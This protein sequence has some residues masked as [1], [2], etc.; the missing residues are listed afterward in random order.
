MIDQAAA[1]TGVTAAIQATGAAASADRAALIAGI[2][3]LTTVVSQLAQ[4][5]GHVTT[6]GMSAHV[7][8]WAKSK[9]WFSTFWSNL[10]DRGKVIVGAILAAGPAAGIVFTFQ[11]PNDG[12]F[13]LEFEHL[14]LAT[15]GVFLWS[16]A[17]NWLMQQAYYASV[18]K[19]RTVSGPT[20]KQ[21]PVAPV[22]VEVKP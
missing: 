10:S 17:Q 6:G 4:L 21:S 19:P 8:E 20:E 13:I 2:Q 15:F 3:Q 12:H 16:F 9:P 11:H 18:L 14:T 5:G 7:L 1:Q 22:P